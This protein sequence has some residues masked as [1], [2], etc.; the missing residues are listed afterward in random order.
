[1]NKQLPEYQTQLAA[2]K[3]L[4]G[5]R[6]LVNR[7]KIPAT[8]FSMLDQMTLRLLAPLED[9]G[10]IIPIQ[11]MPD[12]ALGK[13]FS[14]WLRASK[15]KPDTF[16]TYAHEFL[17]HRPTVKARLY[18]NSLITEFNLQLDR[19]LRDGRARKYFAKLDPAALSMIPWS[20]FP[21]S[22]VMADR[23]HCCILHAVFWFNSRSRES[24]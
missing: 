21:S 12:I 3:Y 14:G 5:R 17:D 23:M 19:W 20:N 9:R 4:E 8:H 7:H 24:W 2:P 18:P 13:M 10:Y 1:M 22:V 11:M 16:P 6:Y 15:Y